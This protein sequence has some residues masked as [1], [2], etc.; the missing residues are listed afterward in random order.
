MQSPVT[1]FSSCFALFRPFSHR[2]W[3]C[4]SFLKNPGYAA[5]MRKQPVEQGV[6]QEV[7][8]LSQISDHL[9]WM[10]PEK[11]DRPSLCAVAGTNYTV[12]LDAGASDAHARQF[13]NQLAEKGIPSPSYVAL[14]HWHWDHVFG[15]AEIG[16]PVVAQRLTAMK[17]ADL[18]KRDW[19]DVGLQ[20]H[21][22]LGEQT[23]E[24]A[25]H[26]KAEIPAPRTVRIA[27]PSILFHN[28][29]ELRLGAVTCL[30]EHVGGDHSPDSSVMFILP[31]RVL[32]LGDCLYDAVYAPKRHYTARLL[33]PLLDRL[34]AFDGAW[35]VSGH[36]PKVATRAEFDEQIAGMQQAAMLV[37]AVGADEEKIFAALEAKTGKPPDQDTACLLR[38]L[39]AGLPSQPASIHEGPSP[40]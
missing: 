2:F 38:A 29:L 6:I 10:P 22:A 32:F 26:I 4:S 25:E 7:M 37:D 12:M 8:T 17:L 30:I 31:D 33:L 28:S 9:Y 34:Q 13:L 18:A 15:A 20:Q 35:F 3:L 27:Q 21:I 40:H 5:G 19:S 24:G 16:A 11:P 23:A 14:T 36:E 39:F 1:N